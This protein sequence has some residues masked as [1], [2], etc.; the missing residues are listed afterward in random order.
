[1]KKSPSYIKKRVSRIHF[2]QTAS[3]DFNNSKPERKRE[4]SCKLK[5]TLITIII[6]AITIFASII[7]QN[8][9]NVQEHITTIFVFAVFLISLTTDGYIYG[10][11]S[12]FLSVL[13]I[14]YAF[15]FP[16][17]ALNFTIP[18]NL[19]SAII[20][21]IVAILTS[22]LTTKLKHH[23]SIK[24]ESEMEHM[25]ANLL[26]AVSH[27][28]RT[29]LT[30]IYGSSSTLLENRDK[31]SDSQQD[32]ILL[33]IKEDSEW[34]VRMVENLLSITRLDNGNVKIIK[35]P[36]VLDELIDSVII[37]F[38]KRYSDQEIVLD[39]P[40]DIVVI[41]MDAMLIEQVI[42]NILENAVQHAK[43]MTKLSL[44]VF[45]ISKQAIFEIKDNGCGIKEEKL[46]NIFKGSY[47]TIYENADSNKRNSGIG[48]SVCAT[49]IKAHNGDITA[50]NIKSGGAVFRFTLSTEENVNE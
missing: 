5:N 8:I 20:M 41:P 7:L 42:I 23:E 49:I 15:T 43:G 17:F 11:A 28:L 45:T 25:R 3:Y 29:P 40:E 44:K 22:T 19:T 30:T 48:L 36:T 6:F 47:E 16:F 27:D 18:V 26:R 50:E 9:F 38:K 21:I 31:L 13:A 14:N 34:L 1:M 10:I 33:G 24:A 39:I 32:K 2:G 12:A 4:I 37:K 46:K 35:S